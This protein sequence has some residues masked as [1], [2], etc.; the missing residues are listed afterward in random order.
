MSKINKFVMF[1]GLSCLALLISVYTLTLVGVI[2]LRITNNLTFPLYIDFA[3][4]FIMFMINLFF[5]LGVSLRVSGKILFRTV[6]GYIPIYIVSM[7]MLD[8]N[9]ISTMLI[10]IIY[11]FI[12]NQILHIK[13][14]GFILRTL[15]FIVLIPVYQLIS[16][17]IKLYNFG[18]D[19]YQYDCNILTTFLYSIDLYLVYI[20]YYWVV[21]KNEKMGWKSFLFTKGKRIPKDT[22]FRKK[23]YLDISELN[24][25]QRVVF[26]TLTVAYQ[27]FQLIVVLTIGL[28]NNMIFELIVMLIIFWVGRKILSKCWHN[29]VL[30]LC[31]LV[32]FIGVY[33]LTKIALPFSV[34]LFSSIALSGVFTYILYYIAIKQEQFD[35]PEFKL[36]NRCDE[37]GL[38]K[39]MT[40]FVIDWKINEITIK[41][42]AAKCFITPESVRQR[43]NRLSKKI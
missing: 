2:D 38:S 34:S 17:Y 10:L 1:I 25:R 5:M 27:I 41:E 30:W 16:G 18:F 29:D 35:D 42:Q 9:M 14:K 31:S 21:I 39:E 4:N 26:I 36:R 32:T 20:F 19:F 37:I 24:G 22:G 8:A 13:F 3:G 11:C 40:D 43:R 28:I 6:V 23:D 12:I 15:V 7:W 33:A